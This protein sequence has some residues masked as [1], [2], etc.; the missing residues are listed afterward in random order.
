[1]E[2]LWAGMGVKMKKPSMGGIVI[3]WNSTMLFSQ[4]IHATSLEMNSS[5]TLG[6]VEW[7]G[8][9]VGTG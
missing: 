4:Y 9:G 6:G 8:G 1:M 3:F 5:D 7:E 2:I